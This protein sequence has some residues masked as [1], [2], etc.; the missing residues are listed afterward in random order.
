MKL[1]EVSIMRRAKS[2]SD[3]NNEQHYIFYVCLALVIAIAVFGIAR[4]LIAAS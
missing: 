1:L 4:D 3:V 2:L